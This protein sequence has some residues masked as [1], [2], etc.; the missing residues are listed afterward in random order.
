MFS[1]V[2]SLCPIVRWAAP[3]VACVALSVPALAQPVR[4]FPANAL[5]GEVT[6][7]QPPAAVLNGR[8]A[9]LAPGV[10]IRDEANLIQLSGSLSGRK[11]VVHY[12]TD[13]HGQ[14]LDVWVLRP[15]E[16]ANVPWPR[17]REE[18]A[19]WAFNPD[20]QTWTKP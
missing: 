9:Q 12:T 18:A 19:A 16:R 17:T 3:L 6:I 5:R 8:P 15:D 13:L 2:S 7:G 11:L 20:T 1:C 10:R 4:T 14:L